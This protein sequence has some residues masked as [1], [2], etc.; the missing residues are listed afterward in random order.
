MGGTNLIDIFEQIKVTKPVQPAN[1]G[2]YFPELRCRLKDSLHAWMRTS[3]NHNDPLFCL[4]CHRLFYM[5]ELSGGE[6]VFMDLNRIAHADDL[7]CAGRLRTG[8]RDIDSDIFIHLKKCGKPANMVPVIV[9][10]KN[11]LNYCRIY[12]EFSHI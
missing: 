9:R 3:R 6:N 8:C 12:R 5:S 10:Y 4:Y 1:K 7:L 11:L 2:I